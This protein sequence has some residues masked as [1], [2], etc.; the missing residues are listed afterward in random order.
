MVKH[1]HGEIMGDH[2]VRVCCLLVVC[3]GTTVGKGKA[4]TRLPLGTWVKFKK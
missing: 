3:E 4:V 1:N 2:R